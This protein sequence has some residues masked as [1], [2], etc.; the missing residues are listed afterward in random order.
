MRQKLNTVR[1]AD[2]RAQPVIVGEA[3]RSSEIFRVT[4][5]MPCVWKIFFAARA[6]AALNFP[7]AVRAV[8]QI[9]MGAA[10]FEAR[11]DIAFNTSYLIEL[12]GQSLSLSYEV[13]AALAADTYQFGG[14]ASPM[15]PWEGLVV[16]VDRGGP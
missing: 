15:T 9:G 11:Q 7:L 5:P 13:E 4:A 6:A 2:L 8:F 12:P 14:G 16:Q 1:W 10:T 3:A